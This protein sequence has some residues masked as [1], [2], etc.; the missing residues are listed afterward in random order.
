MQKLWNT[1]FTCV[2]PVLPLLIIVWRRCC[3]MLR[4]KTSN[5]NIW[6]ALQLEKDTPPSGAIHPNK[7]TAFFPLLPL[8]PQPCCV[9]HERE[10]PYLRFE[11]L[12]L[13]HKVSVWSLICAII[14]SSELKPHRPKFIKKEQRKE[15][16]RS[17]YTLDSCFIYGS[18]K[19]TQPAH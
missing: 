19:H 3:S 15:M 12:L 13:S 1:V 14:L 7:Y 16:K 2:D 11:L 9:H 6:H 4:E 18:L 17:F 8:W 10:F 5:E